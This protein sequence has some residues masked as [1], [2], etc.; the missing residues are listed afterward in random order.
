MNLNPFIYYLAKFRENLLLI[1]AMHSTVREVRAPSDV[2]SVF[3]GPFDYL[4][5]SVF[6]FHFNL[7]E[8]EGLT[9]DILSLALRAPSGR[10]NRQS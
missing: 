6:C 5:I 2:A 1:R 7:A 10:P 9:R 3:I 4:L 8:R